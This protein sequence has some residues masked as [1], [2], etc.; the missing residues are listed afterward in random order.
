MKKTNTKLVIA[1]STIETFQYLDKPLF[2]G[3][4]SHIRNRTR[5]GIDVSNERGR[6]RKI[7]TRKR[8]AHRSAMLLRRLINANAWQ[9]KTPEEKPYTPVFATFT[10]KEDIRDMGKANACYSRFI[11]RLNYV[12][13]GGVRRCHLKY[14]SILEF[15]DKYRQGVIHFHTVFF[16]LDPNVI[17]TLSETWGH[18]FVDAK[19]IDEAINVGR[20]MIKFIYSCFEDGRMDGHKRYFSSKDLLQPIEI[21]E[22][23]AASSIVAQIPAKYLTAENDYEGKLGTVRCKQFMLP[24]NETINDI[25]P[26]IKDQLNYSQ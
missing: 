19:P 6:L 15:Q 10:F 2:Y 22:Q 16:N 3:Y 13:L 8:S 25:L 17:K 4:P 12:L 21:R 24:D 14:V 9:W 5:C 26:E 1:G 11:R 7:E 18:G 23:V 20:Y